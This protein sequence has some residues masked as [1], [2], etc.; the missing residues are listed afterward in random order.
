MAVQIK[1][2]KKPSLKELITF[3]NANVKTE[4]DRGISTPDQTTKDEL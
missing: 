2:S 1:L 4:E 3:V